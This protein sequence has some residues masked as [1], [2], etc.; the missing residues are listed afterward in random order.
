MYNTRAAEHMGLYFYNTLFACR[1]PVG[2]L[3]HSRNILSWTW[4]N[5]IPIIGGKEPKDRYR[6]AM[7]I[8]QKVM[9]RI[10]QSVRG[11]RDFF[12]DHTRTFF[13]C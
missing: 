5:V 4:Y 9:M 1:Q 11:E 12:L 8:G 6:K 7:K 10:S 3:H 2:V 13:A